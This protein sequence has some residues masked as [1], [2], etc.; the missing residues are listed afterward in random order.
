MISHRIHVEGGEREAAEIEIA[1]GANALKDQP[2]RVRSH[3]VVGAEE[4]A[5][6]TARQLDSPG[7]VTIDASTLLLAVIAHGGTV[8][9]NGPDNLRGVVRG[10]PVQDHDLDA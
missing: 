2:D 10:T 9:L 6:F 1:A 4:P 5:V 8:A 3:Y 7:E